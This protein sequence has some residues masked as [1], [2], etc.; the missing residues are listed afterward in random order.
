[1]SAPIFI[2]HPVEKLYYRGTMLKIRDIFDVSVVATLFPDL[3]RENLYRV[4]HVRAGLLQRI[5]GI[6]EKFLRAEL[7]ELAIT[8]SLA[9]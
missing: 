9:R 1:M 2:E 8:N 3:L 7:D 5:S 6:S 4:A